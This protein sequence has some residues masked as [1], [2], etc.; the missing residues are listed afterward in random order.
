[1]KGR[2]LRE[3]V[4]FALAGLR[5]AYA[6]ERSFRVHLRFAGA[7][8]VALLLLRPPPVWWAAVA[9][10]VALVLG[11]ELLNSALEGFVDLIHPARH[12]EIKAVK[13]MAAGAVL[14][15]SG[16]ALVVGACLLVEMGPRRVGEARR[17]LEGVR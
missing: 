10:A 3:R 7:A 6:R 14:V 11:F 2:P 4:G 5:A 12:A 17:W 13:D 8:L 1:M 16:A 9:T 15:M